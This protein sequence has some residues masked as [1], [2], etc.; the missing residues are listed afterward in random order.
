VSLL[1]IRT[2]ML[3]C[4]SR[5]SHDYRGISSHV[6]AQLYKDVYAVWK[7]KAIAVHAS[8]GANMAFVLQPI[9]AG[10]AAASNAA[11]GNPMGTP[12]NMHH[13]RSQSYSFSFIS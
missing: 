13:C 2:R 4:Y 5:P 8:T 11:G 6:D 1:R 12:E 7:E 9:V 10:L 3:L